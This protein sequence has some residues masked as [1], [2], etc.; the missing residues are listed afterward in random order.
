MFRQLVGDCLI[1]HAGPPYTT[2]GRD[3]LGIKAQNASFHAINGLKIALR[4]RH[5]LAEIQKV[6]DKLLLEMAREID[7]NSRH[8]PRSRALSVPPPS[9]EDRLNDFCAIYNIPRNLQITQGMTSGK[10]TVGLVRKMDPDSTT[11]SSSYTVIGDEMNIAA[12]LQGQANPDEILINSHTKRLIEKAMKENTP[13]PFNCEGES[14]DWESFKKE[15]LG[16]E[17]DTH[18][19]IPILRRRCLASEQEG[20]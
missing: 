10:A 8:G 17:Y 7:D 16:D 14:Q 3:G 20:I 5:R 6:Y 11:Y 19:L 1:I 9:N 18:D 2:D 12:R 13:I 15:M 4:L